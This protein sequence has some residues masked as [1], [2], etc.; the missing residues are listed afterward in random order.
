M[1]IYFYFFQ[2]VTNKPKNSY[3]FIVDG[4]S[5]GHIFT[6]NLCNKFLE[7]SMKCEAVLCCRMSPS[8]KAQVIIIKINIENLSFKKK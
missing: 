4:L 3:V 2:S 8:Q 5:L 6:S 7:I 1:K